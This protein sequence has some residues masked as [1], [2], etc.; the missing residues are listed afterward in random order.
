MMSFSANLTYLIAHA[1]DL[2]SYTLLIAS[3]DYRGTS[4]SKVIFRLCMSCASVFFFHCL[5]HSQGKVV[6]VFR[7]DEFTGDFV[8]GWK[9]TLSEISMTQVS[10]MCVYCT[11]YVLPTKNLAIQFF[12]SEQ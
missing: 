9:A 4:S 8:D 1:S 7:K 3:T 2:L 6:G 11:L 12:S 5:S 10:Y